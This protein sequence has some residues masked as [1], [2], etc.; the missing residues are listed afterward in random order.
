[1]TV[2]DKLCVKHR[3]APRAPGPGARLRRRMRRA[4]DPPRF[5]RRRVWRRPDPQ[6]EAGDAGGLRRQGQFAACHQIEPARIAPDFQHHGAQRIAGERVG[7]APQRA[8]HVRRAH[9]HQTARIEAEFGNAVHRQRARFLFAEILSHPQQR[10][11]RR[12][13]SG[14]PDHEP[15]RGRAVPASLGEHLMHRA[16][17]KPAL[18][19]RIGLRMAEPHPAR[20]LRAAMRLEPFD[21]AAQRR[22]R[23][24]ACARHAP[25]PSGWWLPGSFRE[26]N[27]SENLRL[28]QLFMICSNIKLTAAAESIRIGTSGDS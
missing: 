23:G 15:G 25:L 22:K 9:R 10:P 19:R 3:R 5:R 13:P 1:M 14:Q 17:G 11:P 8:V 21:A 20:R 4:H 6:Q 2:A 16:Q 24:R 7:R 18:Q 12:N 27:S 26:P 28:A